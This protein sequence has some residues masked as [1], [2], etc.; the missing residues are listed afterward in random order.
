MFNHTRVWFND[1]FKIIKHITKDIESRHLILTYI[2]HKLNT[3]I[4]GHFYIFTRS[5]DS[6]INTVTGYGLNYR[7]VEVL[8]LVG[9]RIL[10]SPLCPDQLWHLPSLLNKG[11]QGF[12]PQGKNG[13]GMQ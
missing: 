10:S 13:L 7:G 4:K 1:C 2:I 11:Y 3:I 6:A 5:W 12:L 9:S 8:D